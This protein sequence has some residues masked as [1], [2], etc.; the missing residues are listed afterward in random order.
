M[1]VKQFWPPTKHKLLYLNLFVYC[2]VVFLCVFFQSQLLWAKKSLDGYLFTGNIPA[3]KDVEL[4]YEATNGLRAGKGAKELV[5]LL[6]R[7]IEINPYGDA[8]PLLGTYYLSKG[9]YAK[10]LS[11]YDGYRSINPSVIN[12]YTG[13][14]TVFIKQQ[15]IESAK[16]V[17]SEGIVHY[18]RRIELYK[19]SPANDVQK[20]FN[21][22]AL[23]IY[24]KSKKDLAILESLE[25]RLDKAKR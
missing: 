18:R 8:S 25:K 7:S 21:L 10:T 24:D 20:E 12:I 15:D 11:Y 2:A 16:K 23:A 17:V 22:K 5:P 14:V 9:D 6:E 3:S 13:M 4:F 19:P 1:Q